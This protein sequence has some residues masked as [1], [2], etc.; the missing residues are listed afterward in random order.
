MAEQR[1]ETRHRTL[2][3]GLIVINDGYST[4]E[5]MVRYLSESGA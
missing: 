1:N 5:C 2:K 3:P 4:I